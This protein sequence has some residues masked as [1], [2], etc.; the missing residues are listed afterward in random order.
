M[1]ATAMLIAE[2]NQRR[3]TFIKSWTRHRQLVFASV[4]LEKD[5]TIRLLACLDAP[6]V[7]RSKVI[8]ASKGSNGPNPI[9]VNPAKEE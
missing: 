9:R 1:T 8:F 6:R 4:F 5:P 7:D 2:F 3:E